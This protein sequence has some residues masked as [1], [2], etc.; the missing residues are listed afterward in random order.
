G[1]GLLSHAFAR[2]GFQLLEAYE[3]NPQAAA[4]YANNVGNRVRL[5]NIERVRPA[6]KCDALI[7]GP[8]CQGFSTL[9]KRDPNDPRNFLSLYVAEWTKVLQPRVVVIENVA[10][11]LN[12]PV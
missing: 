6:G 10:S 5:A 9:G 12:A 8:P 2:E 11:F 1:A 3:K 7:A 4:T